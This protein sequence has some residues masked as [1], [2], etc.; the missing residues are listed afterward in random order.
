[1]LCALLCKLYA[2]MMW[3]IPH[4]P[5]NRSL[6]RLFHSEGLAREKFTQKMKKL[7]LFSNL[8]V[9]PNLYDLLFFCNTIL[10]S[11]FLSS[12]FFFLSFFFLSFF[13]CKENVKHFNHQ[14]YYRPYLVYIFFIQCKSLGKNA[15][16]EPHRRK[17]ENTGLE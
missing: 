17:K 3:I 8:H 4:V 13:L 2:F 5:E 11:F 16:S 7:S 9:V 6:A 12:F 14:M 1:M 10:S 15:C